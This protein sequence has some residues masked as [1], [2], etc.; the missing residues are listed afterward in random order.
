MVEVSQIWGIHTLSR[1]F[2]TFS[3]CYCHTSNPI[4]ECD[5]AGFWASMHIK[6]PNPTVFSPS[7]PPGPYPDLL[8]WKNTLLNAVS[9]LSLYI[10]QPILDNTQQIFKPCITILI[11]CCSSSVVP[12]IPDRKPYCQT[13]CYL[14]KWKSTSFYAAVL[15]GL[16]LVHQKLFSLHLWKLSPDHVRNHRNRLKASH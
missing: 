10:L 3:H 1:E 15:Q 2:P 16:H 14:R 4:W 11:H 6:T 5:C 7:S 12:S 8:E 9:F 13:V